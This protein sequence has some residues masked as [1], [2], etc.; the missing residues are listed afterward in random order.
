MRIVRT[1]ET[2]M[3]SSKPCIAHRSPSKVHATTLVAS[4]VFLICGG[5]S[6]ARAAGPALWIASSANS[7][8]TGAVGGLVELW[9]GQLTKSGVPQQV[10]ITESGPPLVDAAGVAFQGANVWGD[11]T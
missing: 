9:P 8:V 1:N 11:Y 10:A 2:S 4:L 7:G 3:P 6:P 5:W